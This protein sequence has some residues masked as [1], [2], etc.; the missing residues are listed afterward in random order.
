[1]TTTR[2]VAIVTPWYPSRDKPFRGAF[3]QAMVEATAPVSSSMTVLHCDE[4]VAGLSEKE[5]AEIRAAYARLA[6]LGP[7]PSPTVGGAALR[8]VPVVLPRNL[9][10]AKISLRHE[11][12]LRAALGGRPIDAP[13]VHAHVGLPSGWAAMRN[14]RPEAKL[15]VT[16]HATFLDQVLSAQ[17]SRDCYDAV[18]ARCSGFFAVGE[19]VRAPLVEAF[20]HH[21]DRIQ[22]IPNPISFAQTR[23]E[24]VTR[25]NRWLYIGSLIPRKG[26]VRLV[27]AFAACA[28][29][30]P[31]LTLTIAGTGP[32]EDELTRLARTLGVADRVSLVGSLPP[33]EALQ[34]MREHDLL[35]HLSTF[36]TF[37][38][39][40]VEALAAGMPVLVTRCGGPEESLAGVESDAGELIAVGESVDDVVSG[41]RRLAARLA[42]MDVSR[43]RDELKKRYGYDAV[44]AAHA[45]LWFAEPAAAVSG[46]EV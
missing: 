29:D 43:A 35:V 42:S 46:R 23:A 37:G 10:Y 27:A 7:P 26:V 25:L 13:V 40:I 3:V 36:E 17:D 5:E 12:T 28:A 1:M 15:F 39:T 33:D 6:P 44:A 31:S 11:K 32:L 19:Q 30:D 20:P 8:H 9:T 18:I 21:R 4:W 41:Y 16:E 45:E 2:D 24:P 14:M 38:M 34:L 22:V